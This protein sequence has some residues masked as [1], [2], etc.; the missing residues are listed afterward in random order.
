MLNTVYRLVS[1]RRFEACF[2]NLTIEQDM[3]LVRPEYLS[4]CHADQR[5]YQGMRKPEVL[6]KKLP[7]ALIHEGIGRVV[8]DGKGEFQK[9]QRV[10]MI[11]NVPVEEDE[12]I[13]ENYLRSSK[14]CSSGYDGFM[15]DYVCLP[16]SRF[17][18]I[19]ESLAD[20]VCAYTELVSVSYHAITRFERMS[21]KR[22][23]VIGVWGDGNLGYITAL[24]LK[25]MHPERKVVIMGTNQEK[26]S[27]FTFADA[28]HLVDDMPK[29]LFIDHGF[30]C[31]GG[32]YSEAAINQMI[33]IIKPE[34]TMAILGVSENNV[35]I[36][37][38]MILEKGL[39]MFGSSRSGRA[40]FAGVLALLEQYPSLNRD[41]ATLVHSV[42]EVHDIKDIVKA[43]EVDQQKQMGKTILKWNI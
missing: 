39:R 6:R 37:T 3:V 11:P 1:P 15:R 7:M 27:N 30:E 14:F 18:P 16:R 36:H 19:D 32:M 8:Y 35:G 12:V 5:Y 43:F 42:I 33:D 24:L 34:G 21:H 23:G 13:G 10:V 38:R 29:E 28:V 22:R 31:V 26:L 40:D 17:L 2:Q 4:I 25:T 9:G 41:L 20:E